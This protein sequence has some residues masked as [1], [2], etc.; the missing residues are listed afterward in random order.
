M[1]RY[2]LQLIPPIHRRQVL[3]SFSLASVVVTGAVR[4][5]E[6]VNYLANT[7]YTDCNEESEM[8][9]LASRLRFYR[10]VRSQTVATN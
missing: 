8:I 10:P 9:V 1:L 3:Q 2:F 4:T 6:N 7:I 5:K